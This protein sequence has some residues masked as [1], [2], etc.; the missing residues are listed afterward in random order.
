MTTQ[1]Y[2]FVKHYKFE[3]NV[4]QMPFVPTGYCVMSFHA[5]SDRKRKRILNAQNKLISSL[6]ID[7]H[8]QRAGC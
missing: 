5:I 6:P 2:A 8:H 4:M 3:F 7:N 1:Y